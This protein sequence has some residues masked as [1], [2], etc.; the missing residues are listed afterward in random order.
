M[1]RIFFIAIDALQL[2]GQATCYLEQ[3]VLSPPRPRSSA[4][5]HVKFPSLIDSTIDDLQIGLSSG[6]F[7]SADLVKGREVPERTLR[8]IV[9]GADFTTNLASYLAELTH[10][11]LNVTNLSDVRALT[12]EHPLEDYPARDTGGFDIFLDLGFEGGN[13]N[14]RVWDAYLELL[15]LR[16]KHGMLGALGENDLDALVMPSGTSF[17]W[18]AVVG[19]PVVTVPMGHHGPD[20]PVR[21]DETGQL[22]AHAPGVPMGLSFLGRRWSEDKLIGYAYAFRAEDTG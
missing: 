1:G 15:D 20:A 17:S 2:T 21:H 16:G 9:N 7:T 6:L 8:R 10:N 13:Q 18:A 11:A 22:I 14:S 4:S 12:R 3:Q 19:A 5:S